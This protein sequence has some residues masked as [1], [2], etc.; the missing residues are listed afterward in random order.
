MI[1]P[2]LNDYWKIKCMK[3]TEHST[4]LVT[5]VITYVISPPYFFWLQKLPNPSCPTSSSDLLLQEQNC[6]HLSVYPAA[7]F[8]WPFGKIGKDME[9]EGDGQLDRVVQ[10]TTSEGRLPAL[11][12]STSTYKPWQVNQPILP[13]FITVK[14]R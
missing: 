9:W 11:G 5:K 10:H 13:G 8:Q 4:K 12:S 2:A 7:L 1:T 3:G 6:C 14:W